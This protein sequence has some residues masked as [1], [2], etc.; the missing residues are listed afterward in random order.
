VGLNELTKLKS[1]SNWE[2]AADCEYE[3]IKTDGCR[4]AVVA[5]R[6]VKEEI[7]ALTTVLCHLDLPYQALTFA[8]KISGSLNGLH[9]VLVGKYL[10]KDGTGPVSLQ[11][12]ILI[13]ISSCTVSIGFVQ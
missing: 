10:S 5:G 11:P 7:G 2:R 8:C 1:R 6:G 12:S 4:R 13:S 9:L 3:L